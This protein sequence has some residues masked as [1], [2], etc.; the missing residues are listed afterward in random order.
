MKRRTIIV[1]IVLAVLAIAGL[2]AATA[3]VDAS[4]GMLK[5]AEMVSP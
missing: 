2:T 1:L 3:T 4:W 5:A